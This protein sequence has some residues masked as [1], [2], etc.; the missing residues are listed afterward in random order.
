MVDSSIVPKLLER[1]C[2]VYIDTNIND[3]DH[4][5]YNTFLHKYINENGM[6]MHILNV[7]K[8]TMCQSHDNGI[9][10]VKIDMTCLV[11]DPKRSDKISF[12]ITDIVPKIN[13]KEFI[14]CC[15][16]QYINIGMYCSDENIKCGDQIHSSISNVKFIDDKFIIIVEPYSHSPQLKSPSQHSLISSV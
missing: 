16:T 14:V 12:I 15:N 8:D 4:I 6:I 13:E 11:F 5:N 7:N 9:I 10:K 3:F 1:T 2:T